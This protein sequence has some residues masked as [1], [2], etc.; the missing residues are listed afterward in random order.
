MTSTGNSAVFTRF[1]ILFWILVSEIDPI[2]SAHFNLEKV[3]FG[4]IT[5]FTEKISSQSLKSISSDLI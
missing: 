3:P 5:Y 4:S 2:L 1:R